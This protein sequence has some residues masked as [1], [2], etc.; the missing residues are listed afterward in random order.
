MSDVETLV[1]G[2]G[3]VGLACAYELAK[4][5][6]EVMVLE[7][8]DLVGSETSSRN[9]EVIHA[10]IYYDKDSLKARS[11]VE[12]KEL[13]YA[14]CKENGV[15]HKRIGKLI[16][17][18]SADQV[19]TLS[20]IDAKA[21][22]NGVEDLRF[23]EGA[24][25]AAMEPELNAVAA[26]YSPSTGII[27][28]HNYMAALDG[29]LSACGGQVVLTTSVERLEA[30]DAGGFR[31]HTVDGYSITCAKLVLA[32][33]LHSNGLL[34]TM[35]DALKRPVPPLYLA[36]GNYF[37]LGGRAPFK[38]L[39]YPV[40][41]QGGLGVHLT[42]DLGGGARFGPDVEWVDTIDYSV[43]SSRGDKFY[44]AIR[45][46]WPGLEDGALQAGYSGI[47]PKL[48]PQGAP[49]ADFLIWGEEESGLKGLVAMMGIES[50]G[51]TSSL[52]L[53]RLVK[54]ML[55]GKS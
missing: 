55:H 1:I 29:G 30:L 10:G 20:D 18:T 37:S 41:E 26:L 22:A 47:R 45:T 2:A 4:A 40:P 42:L 23:I 15:P 13:L 49:N 17:A 27:D 9:S 14:F 53:G 34:A 7:Q 51:L 31:V 35:Q 43:A 21:R 16:V 32:G 36:K 25:L 38:H 39:I 50:P 54:D 6:D 8:H 44:A 19:A 24:A 3:A 28:S 48:V 5:G 33:G 52:Y 11:C 12:G 46:Y